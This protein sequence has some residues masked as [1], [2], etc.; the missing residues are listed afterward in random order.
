MNGSSMVMIIVL[1]VGL[2]AGMVFLVGELNRSAEEVLAARETIA[3]LQAELEQDR[4]AF[5]HQQGLI[6]GLNGALNQK[7][8]ELEQTRQALQAGQAEANALRS[9]LQAE[10]AARAA[11]EQQAAAL[12][13]ALAAEKAHAGQLAQTPAQTT[14]Q[15]GPA[16]ASQ[17]TS[18]LPWMVSATGLLAAGGS[19]AWGLRGRRT[20]Q[21]QLP[22]GQVAVWMTREQAHEYAHYQRTLI[23]K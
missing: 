20:H 23:H 15:T 1:A 18:G 11:A 6:D 22:A 13:T 19:L 21:P 9:A 12:T 4:A 8:A 14:A 7:S 3:G 16:A 2:V 5:A 10:Q 17:N